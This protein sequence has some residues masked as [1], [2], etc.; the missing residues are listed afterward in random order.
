MSGPTQQLK[1]SQ[2]VMIYEDPYTRL[3][4]EGQ[5]VLLRRLAVLGGVPAAERWMVRFVTVET[6]D[7]N[8]ERNVERLI[9]PDPGPSAI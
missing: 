6:E 3:K 7:H 8:Y 4:P 2:V 9:V 5:A 1:Q